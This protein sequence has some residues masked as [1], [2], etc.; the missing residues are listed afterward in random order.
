MRRSRTDI[1]RIKEGIFD[2]SR[3]MYPVTIR[4]IFYHLTTIGMVRK[5]E[6][7]YRNTVSRLCGNMRE[8]GEL[9]WEWIADNTRW[10]RKPRTYNSFEEA[11]SLT[12]STYRKNLWLYQ[13]IDVEIWLEKEA[14]SGVIYSITA[15][16][17]VPLMVTRGYPSKTFLHNAAENI[18]HAKPCQIY[19]FGDYDPSG[20]DISRFVEERL[21]ACLKSHLIRL[22]LA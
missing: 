15:E 21:R 7:E 19:Y 9:P 11:L 16:W 18:G 1:E 13:D 8:K 20:L 6:N 4:Q 12:V 3:Q 17:D 10:M 2:F 5:T 22:G 14:L